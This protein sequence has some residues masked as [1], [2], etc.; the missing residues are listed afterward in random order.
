MLNGYHESLQHRKNQ[1]KSYHLII[2]S[3]PDFNTKPEIFHAIFFY[4]YL[5]Q[6]LHVGP[7]Q[8]LHCGKKV[9]MDYHASEGLGAE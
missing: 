7:L 6:S 4:H 8:S 2:A 3:T 5:A 1:I 9:I